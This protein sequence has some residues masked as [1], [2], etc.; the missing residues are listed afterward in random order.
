VNDA[1]GFGSLRVLSGKEQKLGRKPA[2]E[3]VWAIVQQVSAPD[4]LQMAG[5]HPAMFSIP[6]CNSLTAGTARLFEGELIPF[7]RAGFDPLEVRQSIIARPFEHERLRFQ[8]ET[9]R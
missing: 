1:Q 3:Q 5:Q 7:E 6:R 9:L 4:R 2:K 8:K